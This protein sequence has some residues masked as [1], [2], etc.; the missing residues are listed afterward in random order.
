MKKRT[1]HKRNKRSKEIW[2]TLY[3]LQWYSLSSTQPDTDRPNYRWVETPPRAL[4]AP[5][6]C[7]DSSTWQLCQTARNGA[8]Y[9]LWLQRIT[10]ENALWK[11]QPRNL[12][13]SAC[14]CQISETDSPFSFSI[15]FNILVLSNRSLKPPKLRLMQSH[16]CYLIEGRVRCF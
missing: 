10:T 3:S 13:F 5:K 12:P 4:H 7:S 14:T 2:S 11:D 1:E 9:L 15:F 8:V 6:T 16:I